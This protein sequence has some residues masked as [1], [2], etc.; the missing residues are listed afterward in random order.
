MMTPIA[1]DD[2]MAGGAAN[3]HDSAV[4]ETRFG[5]VV[6]SVGLTVERG[7]IA[8]QHRLV[9][10]AEPEAVAAV[11]RFVADVGIART[12][13]LNAVVVGIGSVVLHKHI[14]ARHPAIEHANEDAVAALGDVVAEPIVLIRAA[15]DQHGSRIARMDFPSGTVNADAV[16]KDVPEKTIARGSPQLRAR[17]GAVGEIVVLDQILV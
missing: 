13:G 12:P 1:A 17:I 10:A 16:G 6:I 7:F 9:A 4:P 15:L 8:D 2:G 11:V 5:R 3:D 14:S